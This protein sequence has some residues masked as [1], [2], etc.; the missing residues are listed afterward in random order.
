[1][2]AVLPLHLRWALFCFGVG[3]AVILGPRRAGFL[4]ML[5]TFVAGKDTL[6]SFLHPALSP[7]AMEAVGAAPSKER[8]PLARL[9]CEE[10][11]ESSLTLRGLFKDP[12]QCDLQCSNVASLDASLLR[13]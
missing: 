7:L 5:S 12:C 8:S 1:M 10:A 4:L 13:I 2:G 11:V 9:A 3:L 6:Y